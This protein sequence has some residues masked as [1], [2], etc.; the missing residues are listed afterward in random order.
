M[1]IDLTIEQQVRL[2]T[3]EEE[4]DV[5]VKQAHEQLLQSGMA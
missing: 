1:L 2:M 4:L 5:I 3:S